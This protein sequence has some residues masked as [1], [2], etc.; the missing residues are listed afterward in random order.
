MLTTAS[1]KDVIVSK[2]GGRSASDRWRAAQA[3]MG[4]A[5]HPPHPA[6]DVRLS[7]VCPF[8][9]NMISYRQVVI[10]PI[11]STSLRLVYVHPKPSPSL[12]P[13]PIYVHAWNPNKHDA[14]RTL[15]CQSIR[16]LRVPQP[17]LDAIRLFITMV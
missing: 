14:G 10:I 13:Q 3:A 8:Q 15:P 7:L 6:T 11:L 12:I 17:A 4:W 2:D 16:G 9:V 1:T 5:S